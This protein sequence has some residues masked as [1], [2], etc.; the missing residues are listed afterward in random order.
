MFRAVSVTISTLAFMLAM[1]N[2]SDAGPFRCRPRHCQRRCCPPQQSC[3][4]YGNGGVGD[5]VGELRNE[6]GQLRNQVGKLNTEVRNLRGEVERLK[7][8]P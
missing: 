7:K 8:K 6:V 2:S 5:D 3:P 1:P 4:D